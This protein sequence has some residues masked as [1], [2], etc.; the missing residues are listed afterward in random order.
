MNPRLQDLGGDMTN[1]LHKA[2]VQICDG[3]LQSAIEIFEC[4]ISSD[5]MNIEVWEA[6][7]QLSKT[8]KEL[9]RL[10]DRILQ[11]AELDPADRGSILDYYYFLRQRLKPY[12]RET[13]S[14]PTI[15]FELVDQFVYPL[16]DRQ[17]PSNEF[18][19]GNIFPDNFI[20]FLKR[21]LITSYL[22]LFALAVSLISVGSS[23][24]YW[25]IVVLILNI[26]ATTHNFHSFGL[27]DWRRI[28][29]LP[30]EIIM[31]RDNDISCKPE[32]VR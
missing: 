26:L 32:M 19:S 30:S 8:C 12:D 17:L 25:A 6:Y 7:M 21:M 11:I 28:N 16:N 1:L 5:P 29:A 24:G 2:Y 13:A 3:N 22:I 31:F 9:D 4:L 20:V 18:K 14:Q 10:C 27:S 23:F 15:T